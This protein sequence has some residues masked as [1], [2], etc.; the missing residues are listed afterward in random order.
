[1]RSHPLWWVLVV[2]LVGPAGCKD[3]ETA[4]RQAR[5]QTSDQKL[6]EGRRL[7]DSGEYDKAVT[8]LRAA[9]SANPQDAAP[10]V[11]MAEAQ[12]RAGNEGAAILSL[13]QAQDLSRGD[14][15]VKKSLADLYRRS[16]NKA[17][18]I[19][20]LR[21]LRDQSLLTDPEILVLSRLEA[22]EGDI[23]GAF[24]TLE[25]IQRRNPDDADAKV[26]EAEILLLKGDELLAAN[27]MDRLVNESGLPDAWLLRA[28][29]FLN[30]GRADLAE[31]DLGRITGEAAERRD[32]VQLRARVLN[33]LKRHDEAE[34]ALR[35]LLEKRPHDEELIAQVAESVLYQG[36]PTEAEELV[37][38]ALSKRPRYPRALYVRARALEAQGELKR[39]AENYQ[40]ALKSDPSFAPALSRIWRIYQHRGEKAEAMSALERLFFMG[41]ASLEE[42]V[43]LAELYADS[44]TNVVRGRRLIDEALRREPDSPRLKELRSRLVKL[45][46]GGSREQKGPIII[47]GGR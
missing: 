9:A 17:Q 25:A 21:E 37:D 10:Y 38:R 34:A 19:K 7:I 27:L 39:A 4:A 29:Y 40:Y 13:K 2:A 45:G 30:S 44:K 14:P 47:R 23:E 18:A 1:M 28:R 33:D 41:D 8:A 12:Q 46:G 22:H 42:K 3:P 16:G 43:A 11:L 31:S 5:Q 35:Q 20:V 32:V 15:T 6:A 26:L 36:R 24:R